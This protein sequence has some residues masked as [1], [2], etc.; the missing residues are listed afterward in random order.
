MAT[1]P[2]ALSARKR[3]DNDGGGRREAGLAA[4]DVEEFFR[5][6]IGAEARFGH[7][8][9]GEREA[10]GRRDHRIAAMRDIGE[11]AAVDEGRR[12]F[13]RLHEIRRQRVLEQ[14]GH[15]ASGL[16]IFGRDRLFVRSIGDDDF[17]EPLLQILEIA[18]EA[19]DRHHFGGDRDVEAVLAR[20]AVGDAAERDD[21]LAQRAVVH[22]DDAAQRDAAR[23]DRRLIAPIDVIVDHRREQIVRGGDGVEIAGEM[24]VDRLHRHDLGIAAAG[25]AALHAEAGA[26]RG[27]TQGD[28]ALLADMAQRI[29]EAD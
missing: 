21:D 25:G 4:F 15:R 9:I 11:R 13:E 19:E 22:V 20:I 29:G 2:C 17:A 6:E 26:E 3:R 23:V 18:G 16:Q 8:V 28:D 1:P 7:G 10:R 5:A 14:H 27:L 24:Q 12:A